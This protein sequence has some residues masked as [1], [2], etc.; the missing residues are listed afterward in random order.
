MASAEE[1]AQEAFVKA[2]LRWPRVAAME[3][4]ASW[5]YVV[6]VRH[7][8]RGKRRALDR[9]SAAADVQRDVADAVIDRLEQRRL[10]V[11]TLAPRQR[12]MVVLRYHCD[13]R[14]EEIA[15]ATGTSVGTVKSTLHTALG[16]L[17]V[18][19][20]EAEVGDAR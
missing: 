4:P 12:L 16:R 9:P 11:E 8:Y 1:A 13:L 5:V 6:A 7:A 15:E 17:R 20:M 18:D 10:L 14:L 2:W 19:G 3:R